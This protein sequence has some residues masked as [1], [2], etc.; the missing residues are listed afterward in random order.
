MKVRLLIS[1]LLFSIGSKGA[2]C[3]NVVFPDTTKNELLISRAKRH[4]GKPYL[5]HTLDQTIDEKLIVRMDGFDCTTLVETVV[6]EVNAPKNVKVHVQKTRYRDGLIIDYASRIHYFTEWIYENSKNGIVEDMTKSIPG[7]QPFVAPVNFMS[8]NKNK[9]KQLA[10]DPIQLE[11]IKV[12]E[13]R[14]SEYTW[15]YI[16]KNKLPKI[17]KYIQHGDII[18]ITSNVKG[19]DIAHLGFAHKAKGKLTLL[20]ASTDQKKVVNT[21]KTLHQYLMGNPKQTGFLVLRLK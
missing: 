9:Y 6:A 3:F 13:S 7:S 2:N 1:F 5:A 12:M 8:K 20:H 10:N 14:V 11:K 19:L 18:A 17:E 16:P 4:I 21:T 15:N